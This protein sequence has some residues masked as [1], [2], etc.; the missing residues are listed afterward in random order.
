VP[1][2]TPNAPPYSLHCDLVTP[3]R[4][5]NSTVSFIGPVPPARSIS[6]N[7]D[8]RDFGVCSTM[9]NPVKGR[10][11]IEVASSHNF[12]DR[13]D[14][15][16]QVYFVLA[17][18]HLYVK[19][20][21]RSRHLV[22][23][24]LSA[25]EEYFPFAPICTIDAQ[26]SQPLVGLT[27]SGTAT[28]DRLLNPVWR[29]EVTALAQDKMPTNSLRDDF[30]VTISRDKEEHIYVPLP[31]YE[32]FP[33]SIKTE[34]VCHRGHS[35]TQTTQT[36]PSL[37]NPPTAVSIAVPPTIDDSQTTNLEHAAAV[38]IALW[39]AEC[40]SCPVDALALLKVREQFFIRTELLQ[41]IG[42]W[43]TSP[44]YPLFANKRV[45]GFRVLMDEG[46]LF[47]AVSVNDPVINKLCVAPSQ[48]LPDPLRRIA[49]AFGCGEKLKAGPSPVLH[50]ILNVTD[51]PTACGNSTNI[52]ACEPD[53]ELL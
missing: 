51:G 20:K 6:D 43:Q 13:G 24:T 1:G 41:S 52:I 40:A 29:V 53:R 44:L 26:V 38:A 46:P 45:S 8:N 25:K 23:I 30:N 17:A 47:S 4:N 18:R 2:S 37:F 7:V 19:I 22:R 21:S 33:A 12:V 36:I 42:L 16:P 35:K 28:W 31:L 5:G 50:L 9:P 11:S 49:A 10:A 15:L 27:I 32:H 3:P 14:E 34:Y 39:T 48:T